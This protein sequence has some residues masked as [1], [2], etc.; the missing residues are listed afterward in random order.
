MNTINASIQELIALRK[1]AKSIRLNKLKKS[2]ASLSGAQKSLIRGRGIDFEEVRV[3][4]HGDDIRNMDWRVTAKTGKAHTKIYCEDK[5]KPFY[6]I[7]DLSKSMQFGTK[8]T[9]KS[10]MAQWCSALLIWSAIDNGHRIGGSIIGLEKTLHLKLSSGQK[11][12]LQ[13]LSQL[14]KLN[15]NHSDVNNPQSLSNTLKFHRRSLKPGSSVFILSDFYDWNKDLEQQLSA[16]AKFNDIN[17]IFIYDPLEEKAPKAGVYCVIED[18]KVFKFD[19]R[20]KK[21]RKAYSREHK[22]K[23]LTINNFCLKHRINFIP[24]ATHMDY[25]KLL[26]QVNVK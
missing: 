6:I 22:E 20:L 25:C 7:T 11:A 8:V 9:F 16:I 23:L 24:I 26:E 3:Y 13:F 1:N 2:A 21:L 18:T 19:S 15:K 4:Q 17:L 5:E 10:V 14:Y 12:A